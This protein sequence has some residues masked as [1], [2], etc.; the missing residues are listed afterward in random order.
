MSTAS[1]HLFLPGRLCVIVLATLG[2]LGAAQES[3]RGNNIAYRETI[4]DTD[5]VSA[6]VGGMRDSS[7]A[8][9]NIRGIS[10]TVN[11]AYLYW[12]GPM[13]SL[14]PLANAVIRLN[15]QVITG[16]NIGFS[17]DNCWGF[18][19]SQGYRADVTSF[20]RAE[21]NGA[22]VLSQFVKDGTNINANGASLL[23]FFDD[24]K[25]SNN[26]DIVLF[27]GNDS[28]A[29]NAYDALGW[30]V[31]LAGI[32]YSTGRG[33]LQVHVSDGQIYE[34]DSV[35]LN[36]TVLQGRG[37]VF[38]GTT[39]PSA[40]DGPM[41]FGSLWDIKTWNITSIVTPGTNTLT[42]THGYIRRDCI[43]L[44]IA[45]INLPAG[46]APTPE[47]RPPVVNGTPEIT[48]HTPNPIVVQAEATDPDGD[49]LTYTI[50]IDE[51]VVQ[52][53]SIPS[54]TPVSSG[55]LSV[56]NAFALGQHTVVFTANDGHVSGTFTTV[57]NVTD[58]TP[59]VLH[60]PPDL[61]VPTDPGKI[62]AVVNYVVTVTDDFPA[63]AV[64]SF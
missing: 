1:F 35:I 52:N 24:H 38:Q 61:I 62:T 15:G 14:D 51:T 23:V 29:E 36:G 30:N 13:N 40:N 12:H 48:V 56:T 28:N 39:V 42:L 10:G 45:V 20:V 5:F 32:N 57:V 2:I 50:S 44:V 26:R 63:A 33:F 21:G 3:L 34:D 37:S 59:P 6:G 53:G 18:D 9:I 49:P 55:H 60:L 8:V 47:N 43:S 17:D 64:I 7:S 46:A 16:S 27:D 25:S 22:Y 54:A 11:K 31:T 58:I 19:N 41:G 4:Y